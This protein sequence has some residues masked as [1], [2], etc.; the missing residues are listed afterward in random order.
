M[1]DKSGRLFGVD[2]EEVPSPEVLAI[3]VLIL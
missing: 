2:E 1:Y 3:R